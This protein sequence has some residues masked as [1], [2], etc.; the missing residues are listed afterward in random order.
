MNL[1]Q[2]T[3]L[4]ATV[5][6]QLL[7]V[8]G[9]DTAPNTVVAA[10]VYAHAKVLAQ[11]DLDAKRLLSVLE[12][13]PTELLSEYEYEYGLPLKC[14]V[15]ATKSIEER[16]QIL[17]WFKNTENVVN[18]AYLKQLLAI[19]GIELFELLTYRPIQCTAPVNTEQ[20]RYKVRIV[21]PEPVPADIQCI[22]ENYLP[23][24]LRVDVLTVSTLYSTSK[25]Y[26]FE[27][28]ESVQTV[29]DMNDDATQ[30]IVMNEAA[31]ESESVQ[32]GFGISSATIRDNLTTL[33]TEAE[34]VQTALGLIGATQRSM[35]NGTSVDAEKVSTALAL[36]TATQKAVLIS[37]VLATE[38]V[39]TSFAL[40]GAQIIN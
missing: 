8:G 24:Y 1:E 7:P 22:I 35:L 19:F 6:R 11:A 5:L 10:D 30:R 4:Y 34:S 9:Y 36:S 18:R 15:N 13:I 39:A 17:N 29:F 2:A 20:L 32:T 16:L 12:G 33:D 27:F 3:Q 21:I 31:L 40:A 38:N 37:T 23:A 14:T 26:P 25:P 28:T